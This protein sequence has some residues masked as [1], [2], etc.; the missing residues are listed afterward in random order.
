M[1]GTCAL[2]MESRFE[3]VAE[4]CFGHIFTHTGLGRVDDVLRLAPNDKAELDYTFVVVG[5]GASENELEQVATKLDVWTPPRPCRRGR[6]NKA[7]TA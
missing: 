1:S 3:A 6:R 4:R 7:G 2:V 5:S